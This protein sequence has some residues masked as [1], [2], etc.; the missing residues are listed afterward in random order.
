MLLAVSVSSVLA[1]EV[2]SDWAQEH[3]NIAIIEGLV[4]AHLQSQ[5]TQPTT[6]AEFCALAVTL[7]EGITGSVIT[8]RVTF[9]DT[10]DINVEKAAAIGIVSGVGDN[11]FAPD[12]ELTREQAATM[13]MRLINSVTRIQLERHAATFADNGSI[14]SWARDAAGLM[15]ASGIMGGVGNNTFAPRNPYTRE[16]SI[17]TLLR[18]SVFI[19]ELFLATEVMLV[20]FAAKVHELT[21][22]E[23]V[24]AG[25]QPF[26]R[27]ELLSA[28]AA[29]RA[30]ELELNF[31][32]TRPGG[33]MGP[34]I[35]NEY[36]VTYRTAGENIARG[37]NSPEMVV[38]D[39]MGSQ[40]HRQNILRQSYRN[41]GVG[42][43][44]DSSGRLYWVQLFTD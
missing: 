28:A 14:S 44:L 5:Y 35:L 30:A 41:I 34:G 39:W 18:A 22:E 33:G 13:L 25:L 32:H 26:G 37:Q 38:S 21:N 40:G 15:Q 24:K 8:R 23:R 7:Y 16:Q 36:R 43:Y 3:V 12:A 42:V 4:P 11:N 19:E 9:N 1:D 31:S 27:S 6:R 2:P 29:H 10:R 17:V 20:D